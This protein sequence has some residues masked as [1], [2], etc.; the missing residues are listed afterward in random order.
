MRAA[1]ALLLVVCL[2]ITPSVSAGKLS[3]A[4]SAARNQAPREEPE[5]ED[6]DAG[7]LLQAR[8]EVR[9]AESHG[10]G[11]EDHRHGGS[12]HRPPRRSHGGGTFGFFA[13]DHCQPCCPPPV[14]GVVETHV[15]S[16]APVVVAPAY[17]EPVQPTFADSFARQFAPYPYANDCGGLMVTGSPGF[18]KAWLGRVQF[19]LGSDFDG[20]NRNAAGFLLE[21]GGGFGF[22][23]HW[24]SLAEDLPGSG[25]DELHLGELDVL[26]RFAESDQSLMR[27][28]L[29]TVW[30]GDRYD[31]DFGVNFTLKAD[32]APA[33][34]IVL[35]G[36]LDLGTLGDAQHLHA[37]G[38]VGVML[39]RCEVYGGYDYR[40]IGDVEI[41]GPM[42]GMR[43]WF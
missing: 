23:F 42:V 19:E 22:D 38:T 30:L 18:G 25:H 40:R 4:R 17:V 31:T 2:S 5:H 33:D 13:F 35:S 8:R 1:I 7:K 11:G 16:P 21:G 32:F 36:E 15:Y 34:P 29:G 9:G 37:A 14:V 12:Y 28:G 26:Y 43:I 24:D 20:L 39:N 3:R 27:V 10:E 6:D 41:E